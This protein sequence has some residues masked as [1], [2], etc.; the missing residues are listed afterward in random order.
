MQGPSDLKIETVPLPEEP[1]E[2]ACTV[3]VAAVGIN[4]P[5]VLITQ[6][7]YVLPAFY[8]GKKKK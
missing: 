2:G 6:G 5:D 7:K 8:A 4:F 1:G 3:R